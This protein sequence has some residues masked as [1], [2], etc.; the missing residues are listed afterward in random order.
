MPA[1]SVADEIRQRHECHPDG[2]EQ[3]G[4]RNKIRKNYEHEAADKRNCRLLS[5]AIDKEAKTDRTEKQAPKKRCGVHY[6]LLP[7]ISNN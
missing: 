7:K 6:S 2:N 1:Y 5:F 4:I 3:Y